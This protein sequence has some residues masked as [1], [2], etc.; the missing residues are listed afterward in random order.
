MDRLLSSS[1]T[2]SCLNLDDTP[3][4]S[5]LLHDLFRDRNDVEKT[6]AFLLIEFFLHPFCDSL[7][8]LRAEPSER[9]QL[10]FLQ[11]IFEVMQRVYFELFMQ[12]PDPV[13]AEPG[14]SEQR[15]QLAGA[16]FFQFVQKSQLPGPHDLDDL[17]GEVLPYP[18]QAG[19][20]KPLLHQGRHAF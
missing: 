16:P 13:R 8:Q 4:A 20:V 7:Y 5:K 18:L 2:A 3:G 19:Q 15:F 12:E 11:R 9:L 14:N 6:V 17:F 10:P 1:D